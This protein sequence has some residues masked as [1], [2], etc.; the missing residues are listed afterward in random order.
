MT[1]RKLPIGV[2]DFASIR[3]DGYLYIDK[4][5]HI[6]KLLSSG[7]PYFLARPRR[8]GK[9]LFLSTLKYYFMGRKDLFQGLTVDKYEKDWIEYPM[10]YIDLNTS[11]YYND[12][13]ELK[14][15]LNTMI[16]RFEDQWGT[17]E[18]EETIPDRFKG[19]ISRACEKSGKK[20]VVLIDEYDKPLISTM[21]DPLVYEKVRNFLKGFY[22]VLKAADLHIRFAMLTGVTKFSKVSVFSDLNQ[23]NEIGMDRQ[24]S[25]ICGISEKELL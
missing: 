13:D 3:E 16:G 5:A 17:D 11:G 15:I 23:L 7:K 14:S 1:T 12:V 20:V 25:E 6:E 24:Y 2:Q 9:S 4:T 10:F 19:V 18:R 21:D 22:G 8:F